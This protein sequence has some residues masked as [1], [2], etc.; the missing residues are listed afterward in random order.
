M[1]RRAG[2]DEIGVQIPRPWAR[3]ARAAPGITVTLTPLASPLIELEL[4]VC[5]PGEAD[6]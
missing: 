2:I 4:G 6:P 3:R 1:N 5:R